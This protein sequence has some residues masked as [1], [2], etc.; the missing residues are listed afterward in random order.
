VVVRSDECA[1]H[2]SVNL[3]LRHDWR[4]RGALKDEVLETLLA[5]W[6]GEPF[7]FRGRT[8]RVTP[9]PYTRPHPLLLVAGSSR[10]AAR[11]AARLGLPFFPSAHLPELEAYYY[12]RM[13]EYGTEGWCLM[14]P[15]EVP[16]LHIAD[17]PDRAWAEYGSY[18]LREAL[19]YAF[20]QNGG[21]RS[22]VRSTAG[23]V[24]ELRC[25]GVYRIL[26][27]DECVALPR[28]AVSR[29]ASSCIRCAAACRSTRA[30][31]A[32]GLSSTTRLYDLAL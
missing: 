22:A 6:T 14:P 19:T 30:G 3:T 10:A 31:G 18:F 4:R 8:V 21:I 16:L 27:P 9:L 12:A 28:R 13:E 23:T 7:P 26:T 15:A 24:E 1:S 29:R 5:V 32:R 17:D 2:T 11:R 20:W 25:E